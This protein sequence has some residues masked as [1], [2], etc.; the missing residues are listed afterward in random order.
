MNQETPQTLI[1]AVKY[2]ADY[3][4]AHNFL[5]SIRWADGKVCC[6]TCGSIRVRYIQTRRQWECRE[7]H[8]K[9]RFSLKTG[10]IME[11]SPLPLEKWLAALWLEVNAKNSVSSYEIHRSLGVTQKSAW[12]MLH[13]LR[14][15]LQVG[16]FDKKLSGV[17]EADETYVGGRTSNM[18]AKRRKEFGSAAGGAGKAIVMGVLERRGDVRAKVIRSNKSGFLKSVVR[19]NVKKGSHLFTDDNKSY[20]SLHPEYKHQFVNHKIQYVRDIVHTNGLENFWSLFKRCIKGTHISIEPF[21]LQA[22]LDS[23]VFRFNHR[24]T[25]DKE[26]FNASAPGMIGRRLTYKAL[27]GASEGDTTSAQN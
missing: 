12:F 23:E 25:D 26:R 2:F 7:T 3:Q 20:R 19:A 11:Q 27:I 22:Y 4:N 16:S 21:H 6:P 1:E 5:V 8:A 17:V 15:A 10:T 24:K 14:H 13:R 18:H 9:K